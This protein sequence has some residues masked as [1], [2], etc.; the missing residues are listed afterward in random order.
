MKCEDLLVYTVMR[1]T[2]LSRA[3]PLPFAKTMLLLDRT[4]ECVNDEETVLMST[5][6]SGS[7]EAEEARSVKVEASL[8]CA[9]ACACAGA[10]ADTVTETVKMQY[11]KPAYVNEGRHTLP[12]H[13]SDDLAS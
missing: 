3:P 10:C 11:R 8:F 13:L 2:V 5:T 9:C 1:C 7:E 12:L 4:S 6:G